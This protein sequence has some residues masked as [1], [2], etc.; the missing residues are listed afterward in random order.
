MP[1]LDDILEHEV[2][3]PLILQGHQEGLQQPRQEARR[4]GALTMAR[5][6]FEKRFGS[7]P[8]SF[9]QRLASLTE[10]ELG[11][12]AVRTLDARSLKEL[13]AS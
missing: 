11:D 10:D 7:L 5:Q 3:G 6:L 12:L 2:F 8:E 1:I 4:Q 13:F 9:Q